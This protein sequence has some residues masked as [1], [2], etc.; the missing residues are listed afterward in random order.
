MIVNGEE[1]KILIGIVCLPTGTMIY[2]QRIILD[3]VAAAN[4]DEMTRKIIAS[5]NFPV[6]INRR[7]KDFL[8]YIIN[9]NDGSL[10]IILSYITN[11]E[12]SQNLLFLK[13]C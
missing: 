4:N 9:K 10:D 8:N 13:L 2:Y 7:S 12:V 11:K 3:F 6:Y 5:K 1:Y